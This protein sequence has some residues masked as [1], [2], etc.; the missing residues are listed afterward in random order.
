MSAAGKI[1]DRLHNV[2]QVRPNDYDS[3]CPLCQSRRGRPLHLSALDDGRVLL[4]PFC[5]HE[6]GEVL[7]AIGLTLG[8]LYEKPLGDLQASHARVPAGDRLVLI[9]HEVTVAALIVADVLSV[10]FKYGCA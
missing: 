3:G 10:A 4:H 6:A 7:A 9:D 2:R 5:G 1:L 8:D